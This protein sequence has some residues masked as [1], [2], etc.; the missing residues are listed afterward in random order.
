MKQIFQ[1]NKFVLRARLVLLALMLLSVAWG[2]SESSQFEQITPAQS[3]S[4]TPFQPPTAIS[5][6]L[7]R[8]RLML[9]YQ[10]SPLRQTGLRVW[11][12][13]C[14]IGEHQQPAELSLFLENI[15]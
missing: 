14:V 2:Q 1:P 12:G 4:C 9:E 10:P 13:P 11:S 3:A 5:A 15:A 6:V 7:P 8:Q